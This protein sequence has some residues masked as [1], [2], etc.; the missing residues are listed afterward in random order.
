MPG[1]CTA[2]ITRIAPEHQDKSRYII[3]FCLPKSRDFTHMRCF[4]VSIYT[5]IVLETFPTTHRIFSPAPKP[6]NLLLARAIFF[7][8]QIT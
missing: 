3:A 6:G 8:T 7:R 1:S 4:N 5:R 2:L